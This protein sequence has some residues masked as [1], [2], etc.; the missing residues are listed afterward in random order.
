[1]VLKISRHD[2]GPGDIAPEAFRP[3]T[4]TFTINSGANKLKSV[5]FLHW[6]DFFKNPAFSVARVP[7]T[8]NPD[9]HTHILMDIIVMEV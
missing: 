5:I 9:G 4:P 8:S 1:M 7:E 3:Q 2:V 6:S